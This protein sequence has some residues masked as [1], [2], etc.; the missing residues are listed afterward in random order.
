MRARTAILSV[1]AV[2]GGLAPATAQLAPPDCLEPTPPPAL[3]FNDRVVV[4]PNRAG[5]EPVSVV[6][7][8]GS[9]SVSAHAGTTHLYKD[10]NAATAGA[11]DFAVGY[12]NQTLNWRSTDGGKTWKYVGTAGLPAGPHSATSSGF[13]DPD[14]TVD[15]GGRIYNTEINLANVAVFSSDDDG[16]SYNLANPEATSGDRPW[17]TAAEKD[18]LFLYV[19]TSRQ[20]WRSTNGG[21]TFSLL[22]INVPVEGKLWVDPKNPTTGLIGPM[23][24]FFRAPFTGIAISNDDGKTWTQHRTNKLRAGQQF[25]GVIGVDKG[26]NVYA[27][28]AG[29]YTGPGDNT[30]N[31]FLE[32]LYFDRATMT[33]GEPVSIPLPEG[34]AMWPWIVAGDDGRVGIA[35]LQNHKG[36]PDKFYV[37]GAYTLNGHGSTV[38]CS[39]GSTAEVPPMFSVANASKTPM[40]VGGICV[41]GTNCN[42]STGAAGDRRLGDFITT[43]FDKNGTFFVVGGDTT[44]PNPLGGPKIVGNPIFIKAATGGNL[45]EKPMVTRPTRCLAN[46]PTC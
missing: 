2:M 42:L 22:G 19:N 6:A 41:A 31:G 17:V 12:T 44:I 3:S 8:D 16:Q 38:P 13:S 37:Y 46:L 33:W 21:V 1:V 29:G 14:F 9:I 4:D 15:A 10:P 23:G 7:Q 30:A 40:H 5:G 35:W 24:G 11:G 25:F 26:G 28:S 34:D 43:G 18:E 27:A 32:F 20:L 45:L 39:D 36:A